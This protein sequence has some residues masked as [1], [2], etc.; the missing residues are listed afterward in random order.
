MALGKRRDRKAAKEKIMT[1]D[2]KTIRKLRIIATGIAML[3]TVLTLGAYKANAADVGSGVM[4]EKKGQS[5][6]A[7]QPV[8][9][10]G[11][12]VTDVNNKPIGTKWGNGVVVDNNGKYLGTVNED[13]QNEKKIREQLRR[14]PSQDDYSTKMRELDEAIRLKPNQAS[15]YIEKANEM[16]RTKTPPAERI[17]L[18]EQALTQANLNA[19]I[20]EKATLHRGLA[21]EYERIA[22]EYEKKGNRKKQKEYLNLALSNYKIEYSINPLKFTGAKISIADLTKRVQGL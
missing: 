21:S 20:D 8:T 11:S 3:A 1:I 13:F 7:K 6:E 9:I 10:I 5:Y 15:L 14:T 2:K 16:I 19:S 12:Q 17:K 18:Y 4:Y 22:I